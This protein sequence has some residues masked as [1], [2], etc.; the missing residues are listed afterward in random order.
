MKILNEFKSF[1]IKGNVADIGIGIIIGG[2]FTQVTNSFVNDL[3]MPPL[4]LLTGNV[5][6]SS[7]AF[8][9]RQATEISEAITLNYG[10]FI[11]VLLNFL[12][13]SFVI[14]LIVKQMNKIRE[15]LENVKKEELENVKK[16][17]SDESK[18]VPQLEILS[19]IRDLIKINKI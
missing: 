3:I 17:D 4:G 13:I 15:E 8:V 18:K 14:F 16:N 5:D 1:A 9:L 12:I 11:N 19:E 2:A 6:F 7:R 10:M